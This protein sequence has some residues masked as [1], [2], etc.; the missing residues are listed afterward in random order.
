MAVDL[1]FG[2]F[3][4][5]ALR[6]M[7]MMISGAVFNFT[8]RYLVVSTVRITCHVDSIAICFR[9]ALKRLSILGLGETWLG[10]EKRESDWPVRGRGGGGGGEI[11]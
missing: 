10:V 4:I 3:E 8:S 2:T 6:H 9:S 5:L 1:T 11:T 7:T